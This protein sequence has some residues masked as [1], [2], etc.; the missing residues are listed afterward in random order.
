MTGQ[1]DLRVA[2]CSA[3]DIRD[4]LDLAPGSNA[5]RRIARAVYSAST[6][7]EGLLNRRFYPLTEVRYKDWPLNYQ[8]AVPWRIW[9]DI[10]EVL[11]VT[12]IITG[13]QELLPDVDFLLRPENDGPPY[14]HI[15]IKLSSGAMWATGANTW[16]QA[17][18]IHGTFGGCDA[19]EPAG[20]LAGPV[21]ATTTSVAV[22]DS[23]AVGTLDTI[24]VGSE[25]MT[26]TRK[27]MTA[28]GGA[29]AGDVTAHKNATLLPTTGGPWHEGETLLI[30][31]ERVRVT[32]VA[33]SSLV[34][35]RNVDGTT[36][37][38]HADGAAV[39]ALRHLTVVRG[40]LGSTPAG[41]DDGAAVE[42]LAP[43]ELVRSLAIA[44]TLMSGQLESM[45]YTSVKGDDGRAAAMRELNDLRDRAYT[46]YARQS[47]T[48]V[49]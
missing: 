22:T 41:H 2:Y 29:L 14:S 21:D 17:V 19:T 3:E 30:D 18:A 37:A 43:P 31:G 8:Y 24:R 47:R 20:Q 28:T 11:D 10:D 49:V 40:A 42:R 33:G 46:R 4:A 48:R 6:G 16:Q 35:E 27:R 36:L 7:I 26:V 5:A 34:V 15:E 13:Q 38:A 1:G 39:Y 25:W 9:L 12:R 32:D 44:E 45:G 23:A